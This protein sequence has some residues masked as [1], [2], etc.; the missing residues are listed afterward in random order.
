MS[1]LPNSIFVI[2]ITASISL[3]SGRRVITNVATIATSA[4]D[5]VV[6]PGHPPHHVTRLHRYDHSGM[7][8]LIE[9]EASWLQDVQR[10]HR[11]QQKNVRNIRGA[12]DAFDGT[13]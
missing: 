7:A 4:A 9:A 10:L 12:V 2:A 8:S 1:L 6:H 3:T 13:W 11:R 5:K